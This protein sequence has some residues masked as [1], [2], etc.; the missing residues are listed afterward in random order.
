M[1][2][3]GVDGEKKRGGCDRYGCHR[4]WLGE[5]FGLGEQSLVRN[6]WNMVVGG[7]CG[8]WSSD[9]TEVEAGRIGGRQG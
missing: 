9:P 3:V 6:A 8:E 4:R 7:A 2:V 5:V 1:C